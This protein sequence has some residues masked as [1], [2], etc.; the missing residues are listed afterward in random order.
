MLICVVAKEE[1]S[2]RVN[3]STQWSGPQG[4]LRTSALVTCSRSSWPTAS[5]VKL[6]LLLSQDVFLVWP[7]AHSTHGEKVWTW[8]KTTTNN[9]YLRWIFWSYT[10]ILF[11][12][13]VL[14]TNFTI[15]HAALVCINFPR[16]PHSR[17][18]TFP[19]PSTSTNLNPPV[20]KMYPSYFNHPLFRHYSQWY[21]F[22]VIL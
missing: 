5:P 14:L 22:N 4:L 17:F 2:Q 1:G 10:N 11:S 7:R 12:L 15:H 20:R 13:K 16:L 18:S 8:F 6:L 9:K 19:I 21:G 3:F